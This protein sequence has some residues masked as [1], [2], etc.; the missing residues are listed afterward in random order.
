MKKV[1]SIIIIAL[2]PLFALSASSSNSVSIVLTEVERVDDSVRVS[3][4][5]DVSKKAIEGSAT[6]FVVPT[7]EGGDYSW[8]LPTIKI[9]NR[10]ARIVEQRSEWA[11]GEELFDGVQM[12]D[13][14]L[15]SP[16][17]YSASVIWQPWMDGANLVARVVVRG[18]GGYQELQPLMLER[19]VLLS[20]PVAGS[21]IERTEEPAIAR[22]TTTGER[23]AQRHPYVRPAE[24]HKGVEAGQLFDEDRENTLVV[25]FNQGNYSVDPTLSSNSET[26]MDLLTTIKLIEESDDSRVK[27]I[28]V[29]GFTSPEG[30]SEL[31]ERLAW[32]R[33]VAAKEFLMEHSN[34][35]SS[36]IEL[37]NG[38]VDWQGLRMYVKQSDMHLKEQVLDIIDHFPAWDSDIGRGRLAVLKN[39]QGGEPY[40]YMYK[41]IFPQLRNAA[42]IKVYFENK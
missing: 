16:L 36:A 20:A 15:G 37:Y 28:V 34:L 9:Q 24:E 8:T 6:V 22:A 32:G 39:F 21:A 13:A 17:N 2:L 23:M 42:Y 5:A 26:L 41:H 25:Y 33:A 14:E 4:N 11:M 35:E 10:R 40:R 31:N 1:V 29:A 12:V 30:S 3:F 19:E 27:S 7:L 38:S 18:C